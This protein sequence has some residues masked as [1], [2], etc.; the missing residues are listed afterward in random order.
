MSARP[1]CWGWPPGDAAGWRIVRAAGVESEMEVSAFA[2][3]HQLCAPMLGGLDPR[4]CPCRCAAGCLRVA[5]RD[6][7]GSLLRRPGRCRTS[8]P[9]GRGTAVGVPDRRC[10]MARSC[11]RTSALVRGTAPVRVAD[12]DGLRR[13][14]APPRGWARRSARAGRPGNRGR[15]RSC[16]AL[17]RAARSARRAYPGPGS[18][19]RR[20]AIRSR[21]SSCPAVSTPAELGGGFGLPDRGAAVRPDAKSFLRRFESLPTGS[22][23]AKGGGGGR[24]GRRRHVPRRAAEVLGIGADSNGAKKGG[25][26]DRARRPK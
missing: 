11:V 9:I 22:S 18:S 7:P 21:S 17:R 10:A 12:R 23:A 2:G 25:R 20:A 26:A 6:Y 15:R 5:G 3:L 24:A 8:R 14:R 4:T 1:R 13:P 19:P 16:A